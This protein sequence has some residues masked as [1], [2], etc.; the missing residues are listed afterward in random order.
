MGRRKGLS[1]RRAQTALP[2]RRSPNP[3]HLKQAAA[4]DFVFLRLQNAV[5][6]RE[7]VTRKGKLDERALK[8]FGFGVGYDFLYSRHS[9]NCWLVSSLTCS[10][11]EYR[12]KSAEGKVRH[13]FFR[14]LREDL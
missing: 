3:V 12:A 6:V 8:R 13:P 5:D 2:D 4:E 11:T 10:A 14:S 9:A 7:C 1:H